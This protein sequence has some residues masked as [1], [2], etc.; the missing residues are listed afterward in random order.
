MKNDSN[1]SFFSFFFF[2]A[3]GIGY[4]VLKLW[5]CGSPD[6]SIVFPFQQWN[7]SLIT[8]QIQFANWKLWSSF[9]S[10]SLVGG[11]T[12]G[13]G[14][15]AE[16]GSKRA[17]HLTPGIPQTTIVD[18]DSGLCVTAMDSLPASGLWLQKCDASASSSQSFMLQDG[19]VKHVASNLCVDGGMSKYLCLSPSLSSSSQESLFY[20]LFQVPS[21]I[22]ANRAA[23][24]PICLIATPVCQWRLAFLICYNA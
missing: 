5:P 13:S 8:R 4:D 23:L 12:V 22:L 6:E 21:K 24:V 18:V 2:F 10:W 15:W 7:Y 17:F 19:F 20:F 16:P 9:N 14:I 3:T 1:V 11:A